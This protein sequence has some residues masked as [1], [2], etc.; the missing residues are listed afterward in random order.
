MTTKNRRVGN[1]ETPARTALLDAT[2]RLLVREGYGSVAARKIAEEAGLQKQLL[3]YYFP[4]IDDLVCETFV[5]ACQSFIDG[6]AIASENARPLRGLW[7]LHSA[8]NARLF[9]EF[10]AMAN[11]N[12]ALHAKVCALTLK[13]NAMQVKYLGE[14]LAK[15]S[16]D[17]GPVS[18]RL[19]LFFIAAITRS[20][21]LEK[22]LGLL[23]C[24]REL[25]EFV[26]LCFEKLAAAHAEVSAE[27]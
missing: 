2:E 23:D 11:H 4:T 21:T 14:E 25:G 15:T 6:L 22:E 24:E 9:T 8:G 3:F 7:E 27:I 1:R 26:E 10:M 13:T 20:M 5:R 12:P 18:P 19:L 16:L 17:L